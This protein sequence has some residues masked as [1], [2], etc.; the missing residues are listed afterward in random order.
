ML[1]MPKSVC[2]FLWGGEVSHVTLRNANLEGWKI[3]RGAGPIFIST[4]PDPAGSIEYRNEILHF[5]KKLIKR[6]G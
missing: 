3:K 5:N 4:I 2:F 1:G 6:I